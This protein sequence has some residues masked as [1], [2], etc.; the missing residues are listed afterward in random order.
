[1]A[2][3]KATTLAHT[4]GG[5]SS[6]ISTA[7]INRL[8]GL[9][10]DIQTLLDLKAPIASPTFTGTTT[11]ADFVPATPLSHRNM[12]INGDFRV[13][14]AGPKTGKTGLEKQMTGDRWTINMSGFG[15]WSGG[16]EAD[17]PTGSGFRNSSYLNCTSAQ[18]SPGASAYCVYGQRFEGQDLQLIRKGTSSAKPIT[19]SF[20]VKSPKTGIHICELYDGDNNRHCSQSYTIGTANTWEYNSV[21][22]PADTTGAFDDDN[23]LSLYVQWWLGAGSNYT[24]GTLQTTWGTTTANRVVGQVNVADAVHSTNNYW[25]VTGVQLELGSVATPFEHKSYAEEL[26]RC[27][28]YYHVIAETNTNGKYIGMGYSYSANYFTWVYNFPVVMRSAPIVKSSTGS[29]YYYNYHNS[30]GTNYTTVPAG[31]R[32]N[33][34]CVFDFSSTG[35][36]TSGF[37]GG[38]YISS[39]SAYIHLDSEL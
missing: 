1:M 24:T 37:A 14:Q 32:T 20:W 9:T 28:R 29:A 7:E 38:M 30:T 33:R 3:T 35:S 21:T 22:F 23:D 13:N 2:T 17:T 11:V 19:L 16:T 5:I 36:Y 25:Q 8:D 34:C 10:G 27:E 26:R 12:I 6:D 18:A 4:L 31:T 39:A 15:T